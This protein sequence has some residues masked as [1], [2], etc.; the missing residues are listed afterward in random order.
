M[1]MNFVC[2]TYDMGLIRD[3]LWIFFVPMINKYFV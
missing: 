3:I 1:S 2:N